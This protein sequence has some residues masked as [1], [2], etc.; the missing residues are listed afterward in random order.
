MLYN[1]EKTVLLAYP[2]GKTEKT[3]TVPEGI[4]S[5]ETEAF[6]GNQALT[7]IKL[8]N[9]LLYIEDAA[10]NNCKALQKVNCPKNLISIGMDAFY[11][12]VNLSE[13]T[14]PDSVTDIGQNAFDET[15]VVNSQSS[16]I[17]YVGK[18]VVG[19]TD[20]TV[21]NVTVKDGTVGIAQR[22]FDGK[23]ALKSVKL[24]DS[25]LYINDNAFSY[26]KNLTN[27]TIGDKVKYI[28]RYAFYETAILENQDTAV[29]YIGNWL[30]GCDKDVTDVIVKEGTYG[31]SSS[32]FSY[33]KLQ[34]IVIP[35]SV[36]VTSNMLISGL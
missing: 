29:K 33:S 17:K 35:N 34:T 11:N 21:E 22:A 26:C 4:I 23:S 25:L 8:P 5:I 6:C 18:W 14:I 31:I 12:C 30:V 10:F 20:K 32:A 24:P 1:K 13:V 27:V 2:A 19:F 7:E 15:N 36:K 3:F 16:A 28:G 9:S